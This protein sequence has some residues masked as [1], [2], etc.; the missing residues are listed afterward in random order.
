[1][2]IAFLE[3]DEADGFYKIGIDLE[4]NGTY[5]Y[6]YLIGATYTSQ[7]K[8]YFTVTHYENQWFV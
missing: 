4:K 3:L 5:H 6:R 7:G 1:M 2:T 8:H